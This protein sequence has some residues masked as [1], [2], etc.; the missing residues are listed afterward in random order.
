MANKYEWRGAR[1]TQ[2]WPKRAKVDGVS[3]SGRDARKRE[4][5]RQK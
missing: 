2:R 3:L 4:L 1:E 5:E